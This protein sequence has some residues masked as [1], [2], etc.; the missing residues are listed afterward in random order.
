MKMLILISFTFLA[1]CAQ[2]IPGLEQLVDDM[3][4]DEV[5]SVSIGKEAMIDD[6]NIDI[7]VK[8]SNK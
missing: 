8:I 1:G 7:S 4:T 5:C 3:V 2:M 6:T